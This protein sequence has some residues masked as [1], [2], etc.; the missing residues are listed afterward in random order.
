ME[1]SFA[2]LVLSR[3]R[4]KK[5]P[6]KMSWVPFFVGTYTIKMG[7]IPDPRGKGVTAYTLNL[8][9]GEISLIGTA[10]NTITGENPTYMCTGFSKGYKILSSLVQD[11]FY[12]SFLLAAALS[13]QLGGTANGLFLD[14]QHARGGSHF[15]RLEDDLLPR[16]YSK[17]VQFPALVHLNVPSLLILNDPN[18]PSASSKGSTS[19]TGSPG[20]KRPVS[21]APSQVG[22]VTSTGGSGM[23]FLRI[24]SAHAL[25]A[26]DLFSSDPFVTVRPFHF[27][28]RISFF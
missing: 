19:S 7:H 20:P 15:A 9:T 6:T 12:F 18:S 8:E 2:K 14:W 4:E 16:P 1:E 25:K 23:V 22:H 28:E 3:A 21:H 17:G 10:P 26:A 5:K 24:K 27:N 11:L 13:T